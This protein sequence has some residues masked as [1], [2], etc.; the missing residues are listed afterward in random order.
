M[1]S[2]Q[3]KMPRAPKSLIFLLNSILFLST[4]MY[5]L[6]QSFLNFTEM[7]NFINILNVIPK[8]TYKLFWP[9]RPSTKIP[10]GATALLVSS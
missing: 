1:S 8:A 2:L 3:I 7:Y 4:I 5:L 9:A 10:R 6:L